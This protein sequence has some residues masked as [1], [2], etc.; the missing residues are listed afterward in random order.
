[1]VSTC[2][3]LRRAGQTFKGEKI[4][5][6][7]RFERRDTSKSRDLNGEAPTSKRILSLFGDLTN[8]ISEPLPLT[9]KPLEFENEAQSCTRVAFRCVDRYA[10]DFA[11][12][13]GICRFGTRLDAADHGPRKA[14]AQ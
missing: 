4:S 5:R 3:S 11:L 12:S 9:I 6:R 10:F 1:M 8:C 2:G 7:L 13:A 14:P